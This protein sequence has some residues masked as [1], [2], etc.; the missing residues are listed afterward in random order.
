MQT[1]AGEND[2]TRRAPPRAFVIEDDV[3]TLALLS[4]LA[5]MC[6]YE[7][8]AFTRLS[9]A[10]KALRDRL[11]TVMVVDDE[12]P[13]GRG[14]DLVREVKANPRTGHVRVVF[15]TAAEPERRD[16]IAQLG[17]VIAK[18]FRVREVEQALGEAATGRR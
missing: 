6:G 13:D 14:A 17:P 2:R 15:C 16:Q 1:M 7:P 8:V 5:E 10:R 3:Q 9:S 12:L 18:P 11:P 4:D